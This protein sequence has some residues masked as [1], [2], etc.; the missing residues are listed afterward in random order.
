MGIYCFKGVFIGRCRVE[1]IGAKGVVDDST[2]E[3]QLD[4]GFFYWD[5]TQFDAAA[6]RAKIGVVT[7]AIALVVPSAHP[8]LHA[9]ALQSSHESHAFVVIGVLGGGVFVESAA[10]VGCGIN[11]GIGRFYGDDVHHT[12]ECIDAVSAGSGAFDD[13]DAFDGLWGYHEVEHVV[14]GLGV[15]QSHAINQHEHLVKRAALDLDVGLYAVR[16]SL[17]Q[18]H[19]FDVAE[20]FRGGLHRDVG[21]VFAR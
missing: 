8:S 13:F 5:R 2:Q 10:H 1:S 6:K 4:V 16:T 3:V 20:Q 11:T 12:A 18:V 21:D 19:A 7:V 14:S 9:I 17:S 15:G